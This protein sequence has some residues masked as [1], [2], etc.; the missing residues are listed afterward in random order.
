M[1]QIHICFFCREKPN[2]LFVNQKLNV[3]N[4]ASEDG[5]LVKIFIIL[6]TLHMS[7]DDISRKE[8]PEKSMFLQRTPHF[9]L[10]TGKR[11]REMASEREVVRKKSEDDQYGL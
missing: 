5:L 11:K 10:P 4:N 6:G 9:Y 8:K 1:V 2:Q 7:P 3:K